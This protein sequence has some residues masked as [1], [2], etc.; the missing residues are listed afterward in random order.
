MQPPKLIF[1]RRLDY[2]HQ[3]SG[4]AYAQRAL[5][6]LLTTA[7]SA[8]VLDGMIERNFSRELTLALEQG[9]IPYTRPW[10]GFFHVPAE[11]PEWFDASKSPLRILSLP[12]WRD[13]LPHC[14]GL[15][16]LSRRHRD[17]LRQRL[18]DIPVLA[19]RH[20]T[21]TPEQKFD[22]EAYLRH[23]QPIVQIGWWLRRLASIHAL[24]L[25]KE[26]KSLLIPETPDRIPRF[27]RAVEGERLDAGAPPLE[28][29]DAAVLSRLPNPD[30]DELLHRSVVFLHLRDAV[31]NNA[32]VECIVRRTP[33]LVNP[34]PSVREYLGEDYPLYFETLDEAAA[35]AADPDRI[36]AAHR[37]LAA[38][39]P[40]YLSARTFCRELAES[41][42][43]QSL[44]TPVVAE[45][46][47]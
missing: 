39:D 36:L 34:L 40:E 24:P 42:L 38:F 28:Q 3:R 7:P 4:W 15:I 1:E 29:W 27:L 21:E 46:S 19:L 23:G 30:Y 20:P 41:E 37:H 9:R 32:I 35:K 31:A 6:P 22:F 2:P 47:A 10:V 17:W 25:P 13:S 8:I 16:T 33:V 14:R 26:R 18:P 5:E 45:K 44:P 12:A 11:I 43:Y